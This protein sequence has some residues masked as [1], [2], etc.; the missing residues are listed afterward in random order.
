MSE[1]HFSWSFLLQ[2]LN[3]VVLAGIIV[4][5]AAK[6]L[7]TFVA[8]RRK[9]IEARLEESQK[10]LDEAES[11]KKTYEERLGKLEQEIADYK[12]EVLEEAQAEKEKIIKEAEVMAARISEQAKLTYDQEMRETLSKIREEITRLTIAGAEK[13]IAEK[14]DKKDHD[15]MVND[16]IEKLRSL[17]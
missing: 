17:N 13:I 5:F 3:F 2:V 4:K 6:P 10:L 14:I 7:K 11:L 16:F 15:R 12:K 8:N 9:N 1:G